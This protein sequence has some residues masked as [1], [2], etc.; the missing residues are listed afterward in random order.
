M[1]ETGTHYLAVGSRHRTRRQILGPQD[2]GATDTG[3]TGYRSDR[4]WSHRTQEGQI[5]EPQE[6]QILLLLEPQDETTDTSQRSQ[7]RQIL[8]PPQD[9]TTGDTGA[10]EATDTDTTEATTTMS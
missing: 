7:E 5:L 9:M 3:A 8:E 2:T 6:R 4:Y 10:T 1:N